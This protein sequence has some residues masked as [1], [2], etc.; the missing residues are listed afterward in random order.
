[1]TPRVYRFRNARE[2]DWDY[3]R[4]PNFTPLEIACRCGGKFCAGEVVFTTAFMDAIQGVRSDLGEPLYSSSWHRCPM[5]NAAIGGA[6]NSQH[7]IIAADLY[8]P[9]GSE[10]RNRLLKA[11]M[12]SPFW[13]GGVGYYWNWLHVDLG[14]KRRWQSAPGVDASWH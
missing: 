10:G 9:P 3:R 4:W 8:A 7:K 12:K 2:A 6:A 14:R 13:G 1:M 11:V 5:H